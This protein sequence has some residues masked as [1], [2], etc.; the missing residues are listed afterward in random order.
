MMRWEK[1]RAKGGGMKLI[2]ISFLCIYIT[3]TGRGATINTANTTTINT[4]NTTTTVRTTTTTYISA[5][6]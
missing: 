2:R 4:A 6:I 5:C 3:A 1:W